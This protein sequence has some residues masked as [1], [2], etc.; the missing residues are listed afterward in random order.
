MC[1]GFP[2]AI[3]PDGKEGP[4]HILIAGDGDY[5][6]HLIRPQSDGFQ[7]ELVK[8]LGGTVGSIAYADL[9]NDGWLEFFVPNYDKG[10][11]EVYQ[12]FE[13][14]PSFLSE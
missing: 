7:M 12:F 4:Y 11:I 9:D 14:E 2:Y 8:N 10:Y 3:R 13:K 5:S 6:A 1:P